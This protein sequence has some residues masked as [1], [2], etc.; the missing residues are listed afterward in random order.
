[1]AK[2]L[3]V[4]LLGAYDLTLDRQGIEADLRQNHEKM[5]VLIKQNRNLRAAIADL[6]AQIDKIILKED[7]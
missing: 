3:K 6:Q 7:D 1:M 2:L 4:G 5:L